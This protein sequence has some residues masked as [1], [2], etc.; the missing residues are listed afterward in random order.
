MRTEMNNWGIMMDKWYVHL[1]YPHYFSAYL[2]TDFLEYEVYYN[3]WLEK[4]VKRE[5][6]CNF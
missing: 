3:I 6:M 1:K 2:I 4:E 5:Y